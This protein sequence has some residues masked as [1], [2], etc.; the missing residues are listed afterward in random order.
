M[1]ADVSQIVGKKN[2]ET[3]AS[4]QKDHPQDRRSQLDIS[5]DLVAAS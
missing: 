1:N 3:V 2:T 4:L 5:Q